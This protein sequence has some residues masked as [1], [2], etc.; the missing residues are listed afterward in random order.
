MLSLCI[1]IIFILITGTGF[2]YTEASS[3]A[4]PGDQAI[5]STRTD[6]RGC[7]CFRFALSYDTFENSHI[8]AIEIGGEIIGSASNGTAAW[9]SS[10]VNVD[11]PNFVG[12]SVLFCHST[13]LRFVGSILCFLS[14]L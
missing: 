13:K 1:C 12:V 10:N 4:Q 11:T 5:L 3:P 2:V 8:F 6:L 14:Y 7:F 9:V